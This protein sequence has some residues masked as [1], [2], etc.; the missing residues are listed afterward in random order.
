MKTLQ[1]IVYV[2]LSSILVGLHF[3][4]N[5]IMSILPFLNNSFIGKLIS[6]SYFGI[7]SEFIFWA[8]I[9]YISIDIILPQNTKK[10]NEQKEVILTPIKYTSFD[11]Q[12]MYWL[13]ALFFGII[14]IFTT[15]RQLKDTLVIAGKAGNAGAAAAKTI[16]P[17]ASIAFQSLYIYLLNKFDYKRIS[18][19]LNIIFI[20]IFLIFTIFCV[21][22]SGA[23][24][25][26]QSLLPSLTSVTKYLSWLPNG[27]FNIISGVCTNWTAIAFY[28]AAEVY[29]GI[30]LTTFFWQLNSRYVNKNVIV[31]N[32][33]MIT[34]IAQ[35]GSLASGYAGDAIGKLF[36]VSPLNGIKLFML[37]VVIATTIKFIGN[38]FLFNVIEKEQEE[39]NIHNI[40]NKTIKKEKTEKKGFMQTIKE[41]PKFL[42]LACLTVFYGVTLV[43]IEQTWKWLV[44]KSIQI[45]F[46]NSV[47][48]NV[49]DKTVSGEY[50]M[51][52]ANYFKIQSRL[53]I[54]GALYAPYLLGLVF[55]WPGFAYTTPFLVLIGAIILFG[56]PILK[57]SGLSVTVLALFGLIIVCVLKVAKY[58]LFDSAREMV[59]KYQGPEKGKE[60]K[61]LEGLVSRFGK[62][63]GSQ[64]FLIS[65]SFNLDFDKNNIG[66]ML[67]LFIFSVSMSILWIY[68]V[69]SVSDEMKDVN[70]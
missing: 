43:F 59:V 51:Y 35:L 7:I 1:Q 42:L 21:D 6:H 19:Y 45:K 69:Y 26:N 64:V 58:V 22:Y 34:I 60:L 20:S 44:K 38:Y 67:I 27:L 32:N 23:S 31:G 17:I 18:Y 61:N 53:T 16:V 8:S 48:A 68:S 25:L 39:N 50:S 13:C 36:K 33:R 5:Y 70:M 10:I 63:L 40:D 30:L 29:G 47:A 14:F 49:L 15:S 2:V 54:V 62:S 56:A 46:T 66:L 3:F 65:S 41:N 9:I 11:M 28:I 12:K 4:S 57:I 52:M 37:S 24:V 55:N